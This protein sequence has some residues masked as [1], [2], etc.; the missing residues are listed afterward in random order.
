MNTITELVYNSLEL[1][2]G[3]VFHSEPSGSSVTYKELSAAY[4]VAK[5]VLY[6]WST[7]RL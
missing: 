1:C 5:V 6:P 2:S 7:I 3:A 4:Y